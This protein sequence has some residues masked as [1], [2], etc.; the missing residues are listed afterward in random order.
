MLHGGGSASL[1]GQGVKVTESGTLILIERYLWQSAWP[2]AAAGCIRYG[3]SGGSHTVNQA[4][5]T[6]R[7]FAT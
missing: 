2:T 6:L 3:S 7:V 4:L 1:C 5:R